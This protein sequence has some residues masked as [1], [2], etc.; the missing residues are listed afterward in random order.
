[1]ITLQLTVLGQK[2]NEEL[3]SGTEYV[4]RLIPPQL[5]LLLLAQI[6]IEWWVKSRECWAV[7]RFSNFQAYVKNSEQR[8]R[9]WYLLACREV[10]LPGLAGQPEE[11]S[12]LHLFLSM[13]LDLPGNYYK[14]HLHIWRIYWTFTTI[15]TSY[16]RDVY[17]NWEHNKNKSCLPLCSCGKLRARNYERLH[18]P[19]LTYP[20]T[21]T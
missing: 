3:S 8:G 1:M 20:T 14:Q 17:V 11:V 21:L 18:P 4:C 15:H 16:I 13:T 10:A 7:I 2:S 19:Y 5:H 6:D 12:S 9:C